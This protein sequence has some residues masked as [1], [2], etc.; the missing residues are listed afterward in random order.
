MMLTPYHV[1]IP[2]RHA[3]VGE[4]ARGSRNGPDEQLSIVCRS[5]PPSGGTFRERMRSS[6][7]SVGAAASSPET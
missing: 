5:G 7:R 2:F 6:T 3:G 4:T 1:W